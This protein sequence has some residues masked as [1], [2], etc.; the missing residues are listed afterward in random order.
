[1][2]EGMQYLQRC[3]SVDTKVS[4]SDVLDRTILGDTIE[5]LKHLPYASIDL[6][7]VDPPYNLNKDF[8]GNKFKRMSDDEYEAL[9]LVPDFDP[10]DE[11]I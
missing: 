7:I 6:L 9:D 8:G 5:V 2:E 3:I 10:D 4:L 11:Q 1:M